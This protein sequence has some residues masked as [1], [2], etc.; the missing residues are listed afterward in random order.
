[1]AEDRTCAAAAARRR[2]AAPSAGA[3]VLATR[4]KRLLRS[5]FAAK[6]SARPAGECSIARASSSR[7]VDTSA[8]LP[9]NTSFDET[10][11]AQYVVQI[12]AGDA[13]PWSNPTILYIDSIT[14]TGGTGTV[15]TLD[16]TTSEMPARLATY[17]DAALHPIA[18]STLTWQ[19][20]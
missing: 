7:N 18:G 3:S 19:G 14:V 2:A 17:M 6:R 11:V 13:G 10:L 12:A 4:S 15:A 8:A 20:P 16:F 9:S 1:M 5:S